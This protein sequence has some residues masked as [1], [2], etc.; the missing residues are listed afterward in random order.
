MNIIK[1]L[2]EFTTERLQTPMASRRQMFGTLGS[3]SKKAAIA[4]VPFGMG[5]MATNRA[6]AQSS[7]DVT[8]ALMLALTLEYLEDEFYQEALDS[9]VLSND[10]KAEAIYMQISKHESAHVAFLESALGIDDSNRA[11]PNFDFTV[12]GLFNPFMDSE[13]SDISQQDAYGQLLIL[14]QAFEDTG[15]RAYKGQAGNLIMDKDT[16]TAALQIHSVEARH[17]SEI[18]RLR[19]LKGWITRDESGIPDLGNENA[20]GGI[21]LVYGGEENVIQGGLNV[22]TD[23]G[24]GAPFSVASSTQAY[25]EPLDGAT[26]TTIANL[27]IEKN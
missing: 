8:G 11:K 16:L 22:T 2:D 21:D 12:G 9:G 19:G 26:A 5:M 7:G 27:F 6:S 18:R 24:S 25:D 3:I 4:A 20:N 10:A 23:I 15:V 14:A 17:A 13:V 1:F